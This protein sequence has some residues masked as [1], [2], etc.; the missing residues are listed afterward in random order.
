MTNAQINK[1]ASNCYPALMHSGVFNPH[2]D[3]G[4]EPN[5]KRFPI[6]CLRRWCTPPRARK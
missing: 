5:R 4:A 2:A 6:P 1:G 3:L